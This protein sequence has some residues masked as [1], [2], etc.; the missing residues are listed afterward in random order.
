MKVFKDNAGRSWPVSIDVNAIRRVRTA[1]NLNLAGKDFIAVLE[2]LLED[3]V[4]LCDAIYFIC[5]PEADAL[6]VSQDDF[7]GAMS[8][9]AI[10]HATKTF[11]DELAN[12]T[13]NPRDRARVIRV[14]SAMWNLAEKARDAAEKTL[15]EDLAKVTVLEPPGTPPPETHPATA[16]MP[17]SSPSSSQESSGSTPDLSP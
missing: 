4:L 17:C 11:L 6:G 7:G 5:K 9:D 15:E 16:G 12:F 3:A 13:P 8:G 10:E 2:R 1:L 14:L